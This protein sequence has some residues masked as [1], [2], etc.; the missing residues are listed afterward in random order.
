MLGISAFRYRCQIRLIKILGKVAEDFKQKKMIF[1]HLSLKTS[2]YPGLGV[3]AVIFLVQNS[4][5]FHFLGQFLKTSINKY[6]WNRM[7]TRNSFLMNDT[8]KCCC[9]LDHPGLRVAAVNF[10]VQNNMNFHLPGRFLK[11]SINKKIKFLPPLHLLLPPLS[12]RMRGGS[13]GFL[14]TPKPPQHLE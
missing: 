13:T 2:Y 14:S 9:H 6:G 4:M 3:A 5:K 11:T 12:S 7:E 8:F 10:L 1:G